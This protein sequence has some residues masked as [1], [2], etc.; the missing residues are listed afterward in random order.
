MNEK[1]V[2]SNEQVR[3]K[4]E[5]LDVALIK[6][7]YTIISPEE[8]KDLARTDRKNLPV[9]LIYPPDY[10]ERPAVLLNELVTP[11]D[12][13]FVLDY[14]SKPPALEQAQSSPSP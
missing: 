5:E 13:L 2:F 3:D 10:P 1:R 6:V 4:I 12:V 9:N 14:L 11:D 7:D 8:Q